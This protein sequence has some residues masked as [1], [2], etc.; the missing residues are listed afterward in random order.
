MIAENI[1]RIMK[2]MPAS[3]TV[4]AAAKTRSVQMVQEAYQAGIRHVGH[5]YVQEAAAMI[6]VVPEKLCWHMIGHLQRNKSR[7]ALGLFDMIDS[8]DSQRLADELEKQAAS[9]GRNVPVMIEVNIGEEEAKSGVQPDRAF[10]LAQY[11]RGLSRLKLVGIMT[12]GPLSGDPENSRAYFKRT[13]RIYEEI[14]RIQPDMEYLSMG[15]SHDYRVAV[16]EGATLVRLGTAIFG[17]RPT[18]N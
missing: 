17:E 11:I 13:A 1:Q 10:Q 14:K 5:N 7:Q 18:K 9:L 8:I 3:V 15:M 6:P 2:S 16:E 12:M 4:L